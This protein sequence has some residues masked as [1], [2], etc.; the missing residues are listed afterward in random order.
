MAA[1]ALQF[2]QGETGVYQIL[3]AR[4]GESTVGREPAECAPARWVGGMQGAA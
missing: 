2:E 3:L 4:A 1:C